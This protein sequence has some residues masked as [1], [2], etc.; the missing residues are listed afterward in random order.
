[1]NRQQR[2]KLARQKD[3]ENKHWQEICERQNQVD[4]RQITLNLLCLALALH[5]KYGWTP[6]AIAEAVQAYNDQL[7]RI[8]Y[9]DT[10]EGLVEELEKETGI[11]MGMTHDEAVWM[12][13]KN[14][15]E[16]GLTG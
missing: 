15:R 13:L 14:D 16:R 4:D 3:F 1:M 8:C 10:F 11:T 7:V 2:R 5:H 9:G 6:D 12:R